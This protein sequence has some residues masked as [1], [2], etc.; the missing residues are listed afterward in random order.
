MLEGLKHEVPTLIDATATAGLLALG[1]WGTGLA[2]RIEVVEPSRAALACAAK[3]FAAMPEV[4]PK[5]S[6]PWLV[7]GEADAFALAP[8][9]DRGT[10]RVVAEVDGAHAV[11]R[12]RGRLY[13]V[14]HKDQ[15]AKRYEKYIK[16]RFGELEV[17]AKSGGW[18]LV[19]AKK[20]RLERRPV[21]AITFEAVGLRLEAQPGVFSAGK[22][23]PG[24]ALLLESLDAAALA[25]KRVLDLGCG[26]GLLALVAARAG[27]QATG[28][29]DDLGAVIASRANA[30]RLGIEASFLHSDID[31]ALATEARFEAVL[32]NPPFHVGK[33]VALDLPK[34]FLAAA[35]RRLVKGGRLT[36][37]ANK[38]LGYEEELSSWSGWREVAHN[39]H[40]KVLEAVR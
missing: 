5:A 12:P 21:E 30:E 18:R 39:R 29:D 23:D 22:L 19:R 37:V 20:E 6:L 14:M 26:Y 40:F 8:Q 33:K 17:L 13:A 16:E 31:S 32:M 35:K 10:S 11:L 36:L 27:A 3:T 25:Q 28:L 4:S 2:E 24:T 15:G 34:A 1:A 9:T 7:K 38:A